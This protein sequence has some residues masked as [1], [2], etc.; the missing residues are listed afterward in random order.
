MGKKYEMT[1]EILNAICDSIVEYG[2]PH[3]AFKYTENKEGWPHYSTFRK[4]LFMDADPYQKDFFEKAIK[5]GA[6]LLVDEALEI[7]D[8]ISEDTLTNKKG[9]KYANSEWVISRRLQV[10]SRLKIAALLDPERFGAA[11]KP[12][13]RRIKL[14][15]PVDPTLKGRIEVVY[16]QLE[17]GKISPTEAYQITNIIQLQSQ[18]TELVALKDEVAALKNDSIKKLNFNK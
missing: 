4:W 18:V 3:R 1:D 6:Y 8:N 13:D 17:Q 2:T 9:Y 15:H 7:A 12:M 10:E 16:D 11:L 14:P 5:V